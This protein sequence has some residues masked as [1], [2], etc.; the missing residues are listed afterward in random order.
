M[1]KK[2]KI[3]STH[4]SYFEQTPD[5]IDIVRK[6]PLNIDSLVSKVACVFLCLVGSLQTGW[7]Q[8]PAANSYA[9]STTAATCPSNGG[10]QISNPA[11][12]TVSGGMGVLG[13]VY[14][15]TAG[16]TSGGYQT[17]SQS[18]NRFD[19][20]PPGTYS[21][22]ISKPD[23]PDVTLT[24]IMV[25]STRTPLSLTATVA[26]LCADGQAGGTITASASGGLAPIQY[27][28][29]KASNPNISED[30]LTYGPASSTAT[31][32]FGLF[33]VR[34]KDGCGVFTTQSVD[35][36]P[37]AQKAYF[38]PSG[39][40]KDCDE[41]TINGGLNATTGGSGISPAPNNVYKIELF[42]V[43]STNPCAIPNGASPF[44]TINAQ[45]TADLKFD[46]LKSHSQ[47]AIRTTSPCGEV[48]VRCYNLANSL[49]PSLSRQIVAS[50][51]QFNGVNGTDILLQPSRFTAP[52][53]VT[54]SSAA[55]GNPILTTDQLAT[56]SSKLYSVPYE[57]AGYIVQVKDACGQVRSLT[58]TSPPTA[59]SALAVTVNTSLGCAN[60]LGAKRTNISLSGGFTGL[61]EAGTTVLL[62]SGPDGPIAPPLQA[63]GSITSYYWNNLAPGR[64]TAQV[65]TTT[66]NCGPTSF[67]F[68]VPENSSSS[69]GLTYNLTGSVAS[70]C[71]GNSSLTAS[72]NYNG[73]TT[74]TYELTNSN[75]TV[76]A[77]NT[78]GV[79]T[80]IPPDVYS[81]KASASTG[82]GVSLTQTRSF[83]V[84][85]GNTGPEVSKK[86]GVI[87]ENGNT[88]TASGQAIFR[89]NG[90]GP[91]RLEISPAGV[92]AWSTVASN[93]ATADYVVSNLKA[94]A[95]YDFRLTDN[96]GKSTVTTVSIK[97][98]DAQT[99][100]NS[101]QPCNNQDYALSAPD[102]PGA[103]YSWS[104]DGNVI[105]NS[106][107]LTFTPYQSAN[108]GKYV[109][110]ITLPQ[111]CVVRTA[112]ANLNSSN[113]GEPLPVSLVS[114]K[115]QTLAGQTVQLDWVTASEQNNDYF[116][117]ERS[118]DLVSVEVLGRVAAAEGKALSGHSYRYADT[119]PYWGTSY[120]RLRQV[121]KS[122]AEVTY[123]WEAVVMRDET[124]GVMPNPVLEQRFIV[125]LD[126]P[127]TARV[128]LF[129]TDGHEVSLERKALTSSRLEL[130]AGGT[131]PVGIYVLV[132]EER[133]QVRQYRLIM[134]K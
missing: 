40:N 94:N 122:G 5:K 115:A 131:L 134:Q 25:N 13:A 23:C 69:P 28:F 41:Y 60:Q 43:S 109:V 124:Y 107:Q 117:L 49:G 84:L 10:F 26:N 12:V 72:F 101:L 90:S 62:T 86:V 89:F 3:S 83:T 108:N 132:V 126:E 2:Y 68:T 9:T 85:A 99:V 113:C 8:C 55:T 58:I 105:A 61:L 129:S 24:G 34:A 16:P 59:G 114:F 78:S 98:L 111:G 38:S 66:T 127:R 76:V 50:C 97:P 95:T 35:V 110:T 57:S 36:E 20:L 118:K 80:N 74:V 67:T 46:L 31:G 121:D 30:A 125:S 1:K 91:Y 120:Y 104:K 70:L 19:G 52:L 18:A 64:Y 75:N 47:L 87:C 44:Q 82:C 54:I 123:P 119:Q 48:E 56:V 39:S 102:F 106:R 73:G 96:C 130:K 81:V 11:D 29:I 15:I 103:S 63:S 27:A 128:Q 21:V 133:G 22:T 32:S 37:S 65:N 88:A 93:V 17:T 53:S 7:A 6:S 4:S 112:T 79:F 42:D 116:Q 45:S 14:T 51:K 77:R 71:S 33:Q 100:E 92:N